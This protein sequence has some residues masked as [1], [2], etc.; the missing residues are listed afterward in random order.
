MKRTITIYTSGSLLESLRP[1]FLYFKWVWLAIFIFVLGTQGYAQWS[2]DP[3][4]NNPVSIAANEQQNPKST[5]DGSGGVIVVWQD[6][7][8]GFVDIYAQRIDA[9][10]VALWATNGVPVSTA[11][12]DQINPTIVS[13]GNGGAIIA[14][15][16]FQSGTS[17][18]IY[19]QRINSSGIA[20]WTANGVAISTV[21][22]DQRNP[23]ITFGSSIGVAIVVWEDF[24]SGTNFD[25]YAQ[26][27]NSSGAILGPISGTVIS[28][29]VN[30][31]LFPNAITVS[32]S[33]TIITW[34]DNRSGVTDIY[35]QKIDLNS[36]P[37][38]TSNGVLI[39]GASSSQSKP[40]LTA[41]GS[42]TG[43]IITWEDGR[44]GT[45][46]IFA[47]LI[48]GNG[49]TQ[50]SANGI[51]IC[52]A[53]DNQINPKIIGSS[54]G[55]AIIA[56]EDFR[57]GSNYDIYAQRVNS[58]GVVQWVTD[59]VTICTSSGNQTK[60]QMV[61]D[62][63]SGGII[64]WEDIRGTSTDIYAQRVNLSGAVQWTSNGVVISSATNEQSSSSLVY[65]NN[66]SGQ[67]A[68]VTWN[69]K[70]SGNFNLNLDIY[71]Q[72]L[73]LSG[74]LCGQ[75]SNPGVIS[76]NQTILAGSSNTYSVPVV[77]G[78]TSYTWALP[79]GWIGTSTTNSITPTASGTS[80][81]VF[82]VASNTCGTSVVAS[83]LAITV[84]KQNQTITFNPLASKAF[85]DPAFDPS[86][87]ASSGLPV[88]YVSSNT[89]VATIIG[90]TLNLVGV[91]TTTITASQLGNTIFNAA[92]DVARSLSVSKGNQTIAFTT[93]SAKILGDPPFALTGSSS[94]GL[95]VSYTSS[96][97]SI[98]T[99]SGNTITLVAVGNVTIQA[100]QAG[101][102]NY[103]AANQVNQSFCI[104]P[105][106]PIITA[107]QVNTESPTLTSSSAV[108]NKWFLNDAAIAGAINPTLT[109]TA[110]GVYKVQVT[111][112]I[113]S[114]AFSDNYT[115]V[116]T[117]DGSFNSTSD[118]LIY[119]NPTFNQLMVLLPD[120]VENKTV[121]IY[122]M[123]GQQ[124][125]FKETYG[126]EVSFDVSNYSVGIYVVRV[127]S[128]LFNNVARFTKK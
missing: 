9:S 125:D 15:Q 24:R 61:S 121:S 65:D 105:V 51:V 32:S 13:D 30:A 52:G 100:N 53:A 64:V 72:R 4:V 106:K 98:A 54:S 108:G 25:I 57:G 81:N 39:C 47:Q 107:S 85:G 97:T 69:D 42:F 43:A 101:N 79:A 91:G 96:N 20:Q 120:E 63:S 128:N 34:E 37:L 71:A 82:V 29:A 14:W 28:N 22:N 119:P 99:I 78:A 89:S 35:A 67:G 55:S 111:A 116:V 117:G 11:G 77:V 123:N 3:A 86:A 60:I 118:F 27:I 56:W 17:D 36:N 38:W 59:G 103:N 70:R 40:S 46:N 124:M 88:T 12:D 73:N 19:A 95:V 68:I 83:S 87:T 62:G 58:T 112:D 114:S 41:D 44:N 7:R 48:D 92:T 16:S 50:W 49:V 110:I 45:S 74:V 33:Q 6:R 80:G 66:S 31:Q 8:S 84:S 76:G 90:N 1:A 26:S 23:I 122:T 5:S 75:V 10:G 21:A 104:N 109:I 18:D 93:L 115:F 126:K 102:A 94:S 2:T 127:S 113:C